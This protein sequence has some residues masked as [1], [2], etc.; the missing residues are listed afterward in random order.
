M[1]LEI[2]FKSIDFQN[3]KLKPWT[4]KKFSLASVLEKN[5]AKLSLEKAE[6]IIIGIEEDR[7]SV[8]SGSAKAPDKIR[9]HLYGLNRI[10]P[11]F[12]I[13]DLGNIP[14]G[15]KENDSYFALKNVCEALIQTGKTLVILGGSQDLTFGLSKAFEN[16]SFSLVNVDPR[17]DYV[18]G[19]KRIN[20]ENYLNFIFEKQQNL[21]SHT[22][23]AYQ[24]Y[25]TD[26]LELDQVNAH[27]SEA[28]RLSHVRF[29]MIDIEPYLRQADILSFDLNSVRQIEAPGQYFASPN[30]LYAEEACQIARYAGLADQM[31]IA[32]FFN[33]IPELDKQDV[34]SKLMAQIIWHFL[35]GFN[36]RIKEAPSGNEEEFNHFIVDVEDIDLPMTFYQSRKTGRW[37]MQITD[38]QRTI[39]KLIPC[40]Q[41]DYE[42]TARNEIPDRWW[43]N[44]GK[45]NKLVK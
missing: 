31:K 33:L 25:F 29:D 4:Q 13:L 40:T 14:A 8:V 36:S 35:E 27:L 21:F 32:G 42:M 3:I 28:K 7:N 11:R 9:E 43:R 18:K 1:D 38:E 20:S 16:T 17:I 39:E 34:S 12:K 19:S 15:N 10:T 26:G 41:E 5:Q 6:V 23:L 37:W 44:I 22:T 45:L 24:N 30:G 2:Y